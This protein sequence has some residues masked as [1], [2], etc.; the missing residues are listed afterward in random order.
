MEL[1]LKTGW[2]MSGVSEMG[3]P[4]ETE[5]AVRDR[6]AVLVKGGGRGLETW[7]KATRLARLRALYSA[8]AQ[9]LCWSEPQ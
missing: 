3:I 5:D 2:E 8:A 9:V 4:L 1:L 6:K 7:K